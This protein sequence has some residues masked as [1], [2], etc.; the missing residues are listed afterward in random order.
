MQPR[1]QDSLGGNSKTVMIAN[2][3]PSTQNIWE[4][5]STLRFARNAKQMGNRARVNQNAAGDYERM[6][7]EVIRLREEN[8][9][10]QRQQGLAGARPKRGRLGVRICA[11]QCG[12]D[13]AC[14]RAGEMPDLALGSPGAAD[15]LRTP[16]LG[17]LQPQRAQS[18][19]RPRA[20]PTACSL[21]ALAK[22]I[23]RAKLAEGQAELLRKQC[24]SL[25][26]EL[27]ARENVRRSCTC[28]RKRWRLP[29]AAA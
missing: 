4:T 1:V 10:L 23:E 7:K 24:G 5:Q 2:I 8:A 26:E 20:S 15:H 25:K 9:T 18:P 28:M 17:Q 11:T 27:K 13:S 16:V 21:G 6:R 29:H 12:R 3:S 14:A 19:G 22:A